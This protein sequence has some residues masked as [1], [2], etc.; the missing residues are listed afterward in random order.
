MA[1]TYKAIIYLHETAF[2]NTFGIEKILKI[3]GATSILRTGRRDIWNDILV[4]KE[5]S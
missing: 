1:Q 4:N 3:S 5:K 2:E